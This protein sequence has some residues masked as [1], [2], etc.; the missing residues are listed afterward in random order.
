VCDLLR[1]ELRHVVVEFECIYICDFHKCRFIIYGL[2][3]G[4]RPFIGET[5]SVLLQEWK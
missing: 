1:C 3:P 4:F 2:M 5:L